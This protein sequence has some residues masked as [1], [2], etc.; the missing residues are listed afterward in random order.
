MRQSIGQMRYNNPTATR[1]WEEI[2]RVS[3]YRRPS[4]RKFKIITNSKSPMRQIRPMLRCL[5][6]FL[7][8]SAKN[9]KFAKRLALRPSIRL[10]GEYRLRIPPTIANQNLSTPFCKQYRK[11]VMCFQIIRLLILSYLQYT[12]VF[13]PRLLFKNLKTRRRCKDWRSFRK[14]SKIRRWS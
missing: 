5:I 14:D 10:K 6:R 3:K 11:L 12:E 4:L 13:R 2:I 9:A 7:A 1:M 8:E